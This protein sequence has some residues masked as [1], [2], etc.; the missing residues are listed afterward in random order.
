MDIEFLTQ[1]IQ[2][3]QGKTQPE[4][5]RATVIEVLRGAPKELLSE[6]EAGLLIAAH[7]LFRRAETLMRLALEE[8]TTILPDADALDPP[9]LDDGPALRGRPASGDLFHD[10]ECPGSPNNSLRSTSG[11]NRLRSLTRSVMLPPALASLAALLVYLRTLSPAVSI[12]DSG[13]L[14]AVAS[15]LGI[16]HPTGYPLFTLLGRI[17]TML[18]IASEVIVRL[19]IMAALCTAASVGVLC[20]LLGV[21]L[22]GSEATGRVTDCAGH[23]PSAPQRVAA[24]WRLPSRAP[25]GLRRLPLRSTPCICLW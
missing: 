12:I 1:M 14:A 15:T 13:E 7:G 18:P 10:A 5:R 4:L 6:T 21:L 2:L 3:R 22:R 19:N 8:R 23:R 11:M 25:S 16:A 9:G 20:H 24:P 17:F